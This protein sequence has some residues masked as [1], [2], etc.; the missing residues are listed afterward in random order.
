VIPQDREVEVLDA[1]EAIDAAE[2]RIRD[3]IAGGLRL[4]EARKAQQYHMLQRREAE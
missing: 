2:M 1:A 4:D 3:A